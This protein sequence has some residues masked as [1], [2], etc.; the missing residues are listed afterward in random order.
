MKGL[1]NAADV[2]KG[3]VDKLLQR[4]FKLVHLH[5]EIDVIAVEL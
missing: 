5:V 4:Y 2:F 1:L 3:A